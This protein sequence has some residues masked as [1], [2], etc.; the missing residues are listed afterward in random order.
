[1]GPTAQLAPSV[2]ST[3]SHKTLQSGRTR[4]NLF[5]F[6]LKT[7]KWL[8]FVLIFFAAQLF[9]VTGDPGGGKFRKN[10]TLPLMYAAGGTCPAGRDSG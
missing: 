8:L 3:T 9:W 2:T 4:G 7:M 1:M 6:Y 5:F 10:L